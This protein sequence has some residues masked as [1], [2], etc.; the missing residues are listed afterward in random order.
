MFSRPFQLDPHHPV[1]RSSL[2]PK[3]LA[4]K[5]SFAPGVGLALLE[6]GLLPGA[7]AQS[8]QLTAVFTQMDAA[9]KRFENATASV[10][11][12]TTKKSFTTPR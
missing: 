9:S 5:A 2:R 3:H 6:A 4:G 10:E 8:P 12:E 11:R 1:I 7:L